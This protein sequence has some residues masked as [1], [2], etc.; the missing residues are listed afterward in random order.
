MMGQV[1]G[2]L[3]GNG[4][5]NGLA[6][7]TLGDCRQSGKTGAGKVQQGRVT[8]ALSDM[9]RCPTFSLEEKVT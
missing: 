7:P 2:V 6:V 8:K 5:Q 9:Q 3:C 1:W 4:G